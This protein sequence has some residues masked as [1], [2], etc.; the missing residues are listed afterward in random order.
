[1]CGS[2]KN[3]LQRRRARRR[4]SRNLPQRRRDRDRMLSAYYAPLPLL[5]DLTKRLDGEPPGG[6]S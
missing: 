6:G 3:R 5:G 4:A 2:F 1:M